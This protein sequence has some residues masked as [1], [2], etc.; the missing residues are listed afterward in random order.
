[1]TATT[2]PCRPAACQRC[3]QD[4][5][6]SSCMDRNRSAGE[7]LVALAIFL[8]GTRRFFALTD[9]HAFI[10]YPSATSTTFRL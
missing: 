4:Y 10:N 3:S 2:M 1:M 5:F 6:S 7:K 8:V 9:T